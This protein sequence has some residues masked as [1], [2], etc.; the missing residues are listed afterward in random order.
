MFEVTPSVMRKTTPRTPSRPS[1][2]RVLSARSTAAA[3]L[4]APS[5]LYELI[6]ARAAIRFVL[7]L[8]SSEA[9][10][11]NVMMESCVSVTPRL[12]AVTRVSP[13]SFTSFAA[14]NIDPL[15]SKTRTRS[16]TDEHAGAP[17]G[18]GGGG[19]DISR[20]PQS[21]QS[22]PHGH[23]E[24]SAPG[25]PSSHSPSDA[26]AGCN[27]QSLEHTAPAAATA[28]TNTRVR[29]RQADPA[30]DAPRAVCCFVVRPT[31]CSVP[32]AAH[33]LGDTTG[34]FS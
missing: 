15:S 13:K 28:A 11:A 14:E 26:H 1:V 19:G 9:V 33:V 2:L 29:S 8:S 5:G 16:N 24:Y 21:A 6:T 31:H 32:V 7:M 4:V 22:V 30:I 12:N 34:P 18:I 3:M 10:P 25:P 27:G 20:T 23:P 17:G